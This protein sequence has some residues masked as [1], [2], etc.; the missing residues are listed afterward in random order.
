MTVRD[1]RTARARLSQALWHRLTRLKSCEAGVSAI[2]FGLMLPVF[3]PLALFGTELAY[4]ASIRLQI[5]QIAMSVAD[6]ASRLGQTE[7]AGVTP[8][9]T[10]SDIDSVMFGAMTQGSKINLKENGKVILSSLE[11][12]D[13]TG[14]QWFHWQR[15]RGDLDKSSSYGPA[16]YG[17]QD[18]SFT[19]VGRK[20]KT[21]KA[22]PGSAVMVAE[23][24]YK[25]DGLF[26][27]LFGS[28]PDIHEE[29][30]FMIR[31]DRNLGDRDGAGISPGASNSTC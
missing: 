28:V 11:K 8:T 26:G 18:D 23:V 4:Y 21:L 10:E 31:D 9:I 22:L 24:Y 14:R 29:A 19:G 30:M 5:S 6:N 16:R 20:Q 25:Y 15:C 27:S 13:L 7:N 2:E 17:L 12:D 1:T 3:I